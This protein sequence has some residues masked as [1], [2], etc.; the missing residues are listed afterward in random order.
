[1]FTF[2]LSPLSQHVLTLFLVLPKSMRKTT[3]IC[4][5][6]IFPIV[7][8]KTLGFILNASSTSNVKLRG[9]PDDSTFK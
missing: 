6:S 7:Q 4:Q 2:L 1:M 3:S 5:S 9:M 8:A